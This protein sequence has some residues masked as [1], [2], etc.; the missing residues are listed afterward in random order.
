[1]LKITSLEGCLDTY[2]NRS[3]R[4]DPLDLKVVGVDDGSF[5][6][7]KP[8][9]ER[10]LLL[11]VL[12]RRSRILK[13]KVGTIEV[14]GADAQAVL[15]SLVRTLRFDLVMLSG[16]SFAGFNVIDISRLAYELK[17]PVIAITGDR[18]DNRA[19]RKA[20]KDHFVDWETRWRC[21]R[22]AGRLYTCKP[23]KDEP[24]L[25]FEVKGAAPDLAR[26]II[27][28]TAVISRLPEPVRVARMMAKG[29]SSLTRTIR[30]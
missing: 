10:A 29:L 26:S 25:Y 27:S 16:I 3:G 23:L 18:P 11:A 4:T 2:Q 24:K 20:L 28:K 30:S 19:V 12:M 14:D 13:V 15:K 22:S 1:M 17:K 21:V 8:V 6:A 9:R 5:T 7:S